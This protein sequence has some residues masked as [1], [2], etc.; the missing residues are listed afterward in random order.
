M[1]EYTPTDDEVDTGFTTF[2]WELERSNPGTYPEGSN[3][4]D[5]HEVCA[6]Y[7]RW[8]AEVERATAEKAWLEGHA[9]GRDYQADGWNSDAHDPQQDNPHRLNEGEKQ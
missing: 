4:H 5:Y 2:A 6:A 9:A 1:S 8:L 7:R 3:F